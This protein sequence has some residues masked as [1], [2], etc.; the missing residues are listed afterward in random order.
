MQAVGARRCWW[1]SPAGPQSLPNAVRL[2]SSTGLARGQSCFIVQRG[3]RGFHLP[4]H[5]QRSCVLHCCPAGSSPTFATAQPDGGGCKLLRSF[6][7]RACS[8]TRQATF[9]RPRREVT[10]PE[11]GT[12]MRMLKVEVPVKITVEG[13]TTYSGLLGPLH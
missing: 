13:D 12:V 4:L 7:Q 10:H 8:P 6:P 5:R 1:P 2:S 11:Y 9:A 3:L